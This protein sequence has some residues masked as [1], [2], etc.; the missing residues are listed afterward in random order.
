[1]GTSL[2]PVVYLRGLPSALIRWSGPK[3]ALKLST[4]RHRAG[5]RGEPLP[6]CEDN[7]VLQ[8][9]LY[10]GPRRKLSLDRQHNG[11]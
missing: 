11:S 10:I 3:P 8:Y 7:F 5:V 1:M 6:G 9:F 2:F 4:A